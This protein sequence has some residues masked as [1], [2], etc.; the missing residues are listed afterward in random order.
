MLTF[1]PLCIRLTTSGRVAVLF[2][3]ETIPKGVNGVFNASRHHKFIPVVM[4]QGACASIYCH[5]ESS[6]DS[7]KRMD[8]FGGALNKGRKGLFRSIPRFIIT[9]I[10]V[11]YWVYKNYSFDFCNLLI[12]CFS[13]ELK[14]LEWINYRGLMITMGYYR[15]IIGYCCIM[16]EFSNTNAGFLITIYEFFICFF[17]FHD[18]HNKHKRTIT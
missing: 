4:W 15:G 3:R 11:Y 10:P 8:W 2:L 5:H 18:R 7:R 9:L 17:I 16:Q 6:I 13:R 12:W 1:V 14:S